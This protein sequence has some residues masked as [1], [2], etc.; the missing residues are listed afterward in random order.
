MEKIVKHYALKTIKHSKL[1]G[2]NVF[3]NDYF[4]SQPFFMNYHFT[5]IFVH[6]LALAVVS[7]SN[8]YKL[9]EW[10]PENI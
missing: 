5:K 8:V 9:I 1:E 3:R 7:N 6:L 10:D 4:G 2:K